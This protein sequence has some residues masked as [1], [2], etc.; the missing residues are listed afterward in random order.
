MVIL[1][2]CKWNQGRSQIAKALLKRLGT[3]NTC[4]SA[5]THV[6]KNSKLHTPLSICAP[7]VVKALQEWGIDVSDCTPRPLTKE[8][9][10]S[11][12]RIVIM[13]GHKDLPDYLQ[14]NQKNIFWDIEDPDGKDYTYHQKMRNKIDK[15]IESNHF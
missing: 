9:V 15:L 11:S 7:L 13:C 4:I 3:K 14:N 12:D 1:F 6:D 8:L 10:D 5:G 2:V